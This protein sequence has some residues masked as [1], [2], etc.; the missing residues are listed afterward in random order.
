[1][2]CVE[3]RVLMI[4]APGPRWPPRSRLGALAAG[5]AVAVLVAGGGC[6]PP[7]GPDRT[8]VAGPRTRVDDRPARREASIPPEPAAGPTGSPPP[9]CEPPRPG[10]EAPSEPAPA[11]LGVTIQTALARP[12]L[13][14]QS[15]SASVWIDGWGE[16]VDVGADRRLL[17]ASNQKLA[18]AIAA[19][20]HLDG[21]ARFRTS[22]QVAGPVSAGALRGDL[23]IVAGGDPTLTR[24]GLDTLAAEVAASG[25]TRVD[26]SLVID[27]S[28][29]DSVR[30]ADGWLDWQ[31]PTFVGALSAFIVDRN[32][33]RGDPQFL[34][35]PALANGELFRE[36]LARHG[37][38]VAGTVHYGQVADSV[39][40]A[41]LESATI[42]ELTGTMLTRSDN[43]IAE[44]LIRELGLKVRGTGSTEVGSA[45]VD[46]TL[47]SLC[48]G[49]E[50]ETHD[51]AG[52]SR[53]DARSAREWRSLLQAAEDEPWF[54]SLY[55]GLPVAGRT[56]TLAARLASAPTLGNVRA[57]TGSIVPGRALS[58]YLTT[59]GGRDVV[60][61]VVVN[62]DNPAPAERVIDSLVTAIAAESG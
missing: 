61:S 53:I 52:L 38:T 20:E 26:G 8:G 62:G 54:A 29:Y 10:F 24:A 58:G 43:T 17:P 36:A 32:Q 12:E 39:E 44:S 60:F 37:V 15:L 46:D 27:E 22:V 30:A 11:D 59:A 1:V 3:T 56:G 55:N 25:V 18:T 41:G 5:L 21:T 57:K 33:W 45:V 47:S 48:P 31:Q 9:A 16:V 19:L 4:R 13:A 49:L 50:G 2:S 42:S 14:G 34:A 6:A 28:R 40:V 51:G 7:P 23:G 35:D